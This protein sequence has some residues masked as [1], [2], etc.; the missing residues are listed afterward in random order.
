MDTAKLKR[1]STGEAIRRLAAKEV[2]PAYKSPRGNQEQDQQAV[3]HERR[4]M[5]LVTG[6]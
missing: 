1:V 6:R 2:A 4:R 3:E 5:E